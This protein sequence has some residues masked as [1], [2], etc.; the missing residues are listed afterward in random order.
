MPG[1]GFDEAIRAALKAASGKGMTAAVASAREI[2]LDFLANEEAFSVDSPDEP[3]PLPPPIVKP[4]EPIGRTGMAHEFD[5]VREAKYQE[6]EELT[7]LPSIDKSNSKSTVARKRRSLADIGV[8]VEKA[9]PGYIEVIPEGRV[10]PM[11]LIRY[12][13]ADQQ[14][15]AVQLCYQPSK[16]EPGV[17]YPKVWFFETDEN[18]PDVA[19]AIEKMKGEAAKIYRLRTGPITTTVKE[20][21]PLSTRMAAREQV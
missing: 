19:A 12:I 9:A 11:P 16:M 15:G 1:P 6:I 21:G 3:A 17:S 18:P 10:E 4:S 20:L 2:L 14:A 13:M 5:K 7:E 8:I